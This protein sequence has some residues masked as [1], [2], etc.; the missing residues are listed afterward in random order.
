MGKYVNVS[1]CFCEG[2]WG[3]GMHGD[4]GAKLGSE[5]SQ[6]ACEMKQT[7]PEEKKQKQ[8]SNNNTTPQKSDKQGRLAL[9]QK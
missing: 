3:G 8:N 9:K 6:I 4:T 2:G 1:M 5:T 7:T